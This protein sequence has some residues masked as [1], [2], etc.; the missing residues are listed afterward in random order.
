MG[1]LTQAQNQMIAP[2]IATLNEQKAQ[3]Q[4][5][6]D[7]YLA[8]VTSTK[9]KSA[10]NSNG[11]NFN[12]IVVADALAQNLRNSYAMFKNELSEVTAQLMPPYTQPVTKLEPVYV[13]K[14]PTIPLGL[15]LALGA[16]IGIFGGV[17]ALLVNRSIRLY[18]SQN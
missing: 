18:K 5:L 11:A 2:A 16:L 12:Q 7:I 10:V 6:L 15:A 3:S 4:K 14:T 9:A 8:E 1:R 17:V 13:S